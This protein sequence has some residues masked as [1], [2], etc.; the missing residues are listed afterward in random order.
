LIPSSENPLVYAG[1]MLKGETSITQA[2]VE[3]RDKERARER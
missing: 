2:L 1:G 3:D